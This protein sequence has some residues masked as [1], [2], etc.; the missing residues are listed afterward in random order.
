MVA[1][2]RDPAKDFVRGAYVSLVG[3]DQGMDLMMGKALENQR[4]TMDTADDHNLLDWA[5]RLAGLSG[6]TILT[7]LFGS[8]SLSLS[9]P[10]SLFSSSLPYPPPFSSYY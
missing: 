10:L 2:W 6:R 4:A 5:S 1:D 3:A 8:S 9:F 7:E